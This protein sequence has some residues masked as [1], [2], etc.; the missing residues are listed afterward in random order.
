MTNPKGKQILSD[1]DR[2]RAKNFQ[3]K[4]VCELTKAFTERF[5]SVLQAIIESA[6]PFA[7]NLVM[8]EIYGEESGE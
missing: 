4:L 2:K 8:K 5:T 7:V 3:E 6:V 1:T